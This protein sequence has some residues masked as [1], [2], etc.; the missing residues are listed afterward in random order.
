MTQA[1]NR[2]EGGDA[3]D[4]GFL[5]TRLGIAADAFIA[6]G[7]IVVGDVAIGPRSSVWFGCVLRGDLE[8]IVIGARTNIQDLTVV[9][10]DHG[11]GVRIGDGV[12]VGHR[13]IVHGC[14]VEDGAL[15]GMGA[16]LLSGCKIGRGAL[17]AAGAVVREGFEAPDG[18]IVAGVPGKIIGQV[19]AQLRQ[20]IDR[21]VAT[22]VRSAA[23][24]RTGQLGGGPH[25]A[26]R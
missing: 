14:V 24:Y 6:P 11:Q 16:V 26:P 7:A 10:V 15:V 25:G 18:A 22:Y 19:D 21:G 2:P 12:T 5:K 3:T 23:G 8:P 17:V 1:G 13:C 4:A 20:R 9:H